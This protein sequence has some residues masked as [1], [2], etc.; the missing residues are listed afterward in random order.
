MNEQ[1]AREQP[2]DS[3]NLGPSSFWEAKDKGTNGQF[4]ECFIGFDVRSW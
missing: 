4:A 2:A 1:S 3:W